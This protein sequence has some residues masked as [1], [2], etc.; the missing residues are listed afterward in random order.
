V[1]ARAPPRDFTSALKR[2]QLG[3]WVATLAGRCGR[4]RKTTLF[5]SNLA[6]RRRISANLWPEPRHPA[7]GW[8][9]NRKDQLER[10]LRGLVRAGRLPIG[11]AQRSIA[12]DWVAAYRKFVVGA[13]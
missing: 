6:E 9:A 10:M 3:A 2:R 5:R 1:W 12:R 4:K 13:E 7:D 11:F 8:G